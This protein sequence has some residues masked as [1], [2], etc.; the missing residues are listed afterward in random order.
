MNLV[1]WLNRLRTENTRESYRQYL[2][3][4]LDYHKVTLF[5]TQTWT[6]KKAENA[7]EDFKHFLIQQEK[8]GSTIQTAWFA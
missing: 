1:E 8:A 2:Q 5:E 7:M 3:Q 6:V 4:F